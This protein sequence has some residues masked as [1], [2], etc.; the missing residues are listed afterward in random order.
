MESKIRRV[1]GLRF[2]NNDKIQYINTCILYSTLGHT[3]PAPPPPVDCCLRPLVP[4]Q[5]PPL[6]GGGGGCGGPAARGPAPQGLQPQ[7]SPKS[8]IVLRKYQ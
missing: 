1:Q 2:L 6:G 3:V 5:P 8:I 4:P 7:H